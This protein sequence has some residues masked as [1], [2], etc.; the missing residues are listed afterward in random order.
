MIWMLKHD[1]QVDLIMTLWG[2][3]GTG[4]NAGT[5]PE[6]TSEAQKADT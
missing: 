1:P 3:T 5:E 2:E 6:N 4:P